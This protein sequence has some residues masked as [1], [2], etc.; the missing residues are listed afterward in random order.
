MFNPDKSEVRA[1][2]NRARG[3]LFYLLSRLRWRWRKLLLGSR[4][5]DR[6][7]IRPNQTV[8]NCSCEHHHEFYSWIA[9]LYLPPPMPP[10]RT[11]V[12]IHIYF[13]IASLLLSS[14]RLTRHAAFLP[15]VAHCTRKKKSSIVLRPTSLRVIMRSLRRP[16]LYTPDS[17]FIFIS[18]FSSPP[19]TSSLFF[20]PLSF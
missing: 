19:P 12:H 7:E 11:Y 18:P 6:K 13:Y 9:W 14:G 16:E 17:F 5:R 15:L 1:Q 2:S 3:N 20:L 4:T 8:N 10:V